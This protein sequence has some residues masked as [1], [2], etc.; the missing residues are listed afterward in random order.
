MTPVGPQGSWAG[1][2]WGWWQQIANLSSCLGQVMKSLRVGEEGFRSRHT[3]LP[4]CHSVPGTLLG[5]QSLPATP[6]PTANTTTLGPSEHPL[7]SPL[8]SFSGRL[9]P[10]PP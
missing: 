3:V 6:A 10:C 8:N 5:S 1:V 7:L 9:F 2:S 4:Q